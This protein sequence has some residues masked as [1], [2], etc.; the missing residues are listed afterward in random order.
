[1]IAMEG[2]DADHL[3]R[4]ADALTQVAMRIGEAAARG[5]AGGGAPGGKPDEGVVDAEFEE[6]ADRKRSA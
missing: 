2:T 6:V 4:A 1:L 5:S 3:K